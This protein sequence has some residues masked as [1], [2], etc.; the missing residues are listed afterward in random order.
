MNKSLPAFASLHPSSL[1]LHPFT[2]PY[3]IL[4][5]GEDCTAP[6]D[7]VLFDVPA[8]AELAELHAWSSCASAALPGVPLVAC[9]PAKSAGVG[10]HAQV[11]DESTLKRAGFHAIAVEAAQLSALLRDVEERG[12]DEDGA[13]ASPTDLA[14]AS[15]LLPERLGV[16]RLRAAFEVIASLHFAADQRGAAQAAL[17]GLAAVVAADRWTVYICGESGAFC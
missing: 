3:V 10:R 7:A 14:P 8:G 11:F 2:M 1:R 13:G 16:E 12:T 6:R 9:R 15:L 17:A 5:S 4:L